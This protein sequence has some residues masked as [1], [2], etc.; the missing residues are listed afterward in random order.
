[1]SF[2]DNTHKHSPGAKSFGFGIFFFSFFILAL[3]QRY[4]LQAYVL[5]TYELLLSWWNTL[6]FAG[7]FSFV[8]LLKLMSGGN[9]ISSKFVCVCWLFSLLKM[10]FQGI[11]TPT[12][13]KKTDR[14]IGDRWS[15]SFFI[16][17]PFLYLCALH[18][19]SVFGPVGDIFKLCTN[20]TYIGTFHYFRGFFCLLQLIFNFCHARLNQLETFF[21]FFFLAVFYF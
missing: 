3:M 13:N 16:S 7:V 6:H 21:L 12:E 14:G 9:K 4:R 1:M 19:C 17:L 18:V 5:R 11:L 10:Q 15:C 8:V 20:G 2:G